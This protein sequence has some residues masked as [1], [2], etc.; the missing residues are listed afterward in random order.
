MQEISQTRDDSIFV[1]RR[2]VPYGVQYCAAFYNV[3]LLGYRMSI[4]TYDWSIGLD[5]VKIP[6]PLGLL[7]VFYENKAIINFKKTTAHCSLI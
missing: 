1:Y 5:V 3:R 7:A 4:D 2:Y 6:V